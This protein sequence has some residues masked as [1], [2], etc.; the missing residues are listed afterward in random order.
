[1]L[2]F[3]SSKGLKDKYKYLEP[4]YKDEIKMGLYKS[5]Y[6]SKTELLTKPFQPQ[7]KD[8]KRSS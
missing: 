1:M 4:P 8:E 7:R 5:N 3:K 2:R 6:L